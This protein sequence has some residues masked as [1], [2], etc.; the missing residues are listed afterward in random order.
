MKHQRLNDYGRQIS[1][2]KH[3]P[4]AFDVQREMAHLA[5]EKWIEGVVGGGSL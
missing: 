2:I 1:E 5:G 4:R 3:S